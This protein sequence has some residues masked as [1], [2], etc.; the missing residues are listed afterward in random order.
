[1]GKAGQPLQSVKTVI[2]VVPAVMGDLDPHMIMG[3]IVV[4]GLVVVL[5]I[6]QGVLDGYGMQ[7]G[8]PCML[9]VRL[10]GL[11]SLNNCLM[12]FESK[13]LFI[14]RIYAN[15]PCVSLFLI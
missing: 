13:Y 9:G 1:M 8:K 6:V 5:V 12:L 2:I 10:Y 4:M 11:H 14:T 7:G 15:I 3:L